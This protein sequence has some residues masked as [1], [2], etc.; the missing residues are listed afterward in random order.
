MKQ[1]F[2]APMALLA[3]SGGARAT[4]LPVDAPACSPASAALAG[5]AR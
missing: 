5:P 4:G 3:L 2:L 1:P